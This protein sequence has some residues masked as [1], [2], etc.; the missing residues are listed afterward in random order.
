MCNY[1]QSAENGECKFHK[2]VQDEDTNEW[3]TVCDIEENLEE[4]D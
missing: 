4:C 1:Y 2:R 3:I